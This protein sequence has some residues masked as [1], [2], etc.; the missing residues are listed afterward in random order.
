M[1]NVEQIA[2][3][4]GQDVFDSAGERVGKLEEVFYSASSGEA[5]FISLKSGL[6]GRHGGVVPLAGASVG[7][8]YVRLAY[9]AEQIEQAGGNRAPDTLEREEAGRLAGA[10][11]IEL[12]PGEDYESASAVSERIR[13]AEETR[14][15]AAQLEAEARAREE[16]ADDAQSS[17]R[18]AGEDAAERA[19][20]AREA[21]QE[22]DRAQ[23]ELARLEGSRPT[24]G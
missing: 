23:A 19:T 7:R 17:A 9:T 22:A 13:T 14:A 12:A 4:V 1:L 15:R 2:E 18:S 3:W 8:D 11:G 21:R 24:A 20:A 6:L 10:Y 16:A 5:L